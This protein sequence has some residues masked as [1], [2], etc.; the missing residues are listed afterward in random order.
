M[1]GIRLSSRF[2]V[3]YQVVTEQPRDEAG[4]FVNMSLSPQY[5]SYT[6]LRRDVVNRTTMQGRGLCLIHIGATT[7]IRKFRISAALIDCSDGNAKCVP[8]KCK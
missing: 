1:P 4:S 2:V 6:I 3:R 8:G 7:L 5:S